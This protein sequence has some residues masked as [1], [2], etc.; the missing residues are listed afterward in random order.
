[1]TERPT[2]IRGDVSESAWVA[3][4]SPIDAAIFDVPHGQPAPAQVGEHTLSLSGSLGISVYPE[5]GTDADTLIDCA[6]A[7]MY[8]VKDRGKNGIQAAVLGR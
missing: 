2:S 7:A 8:R 3:T 1:M 4:S 6:D 5:D